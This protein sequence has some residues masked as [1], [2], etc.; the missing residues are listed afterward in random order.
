MTRARLIAIAGG[1]IACGV[2]AVVYQFAPTEH[3]FYPRCP[4]YALTGWQ[5]PGCGATR[6]LHALL[7]GHL[8]SAWAYNQLFVALLPLIVMFAVLQFGHAIW[9]GRWYSL[10]LQPR[11]IYS[12]LAMMLCF[13]VIRNL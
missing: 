10:R 6:A 7:H 11:L 8:A 5:C 4:L 2:C 1:A 12:G 3:S 13:G 9:R